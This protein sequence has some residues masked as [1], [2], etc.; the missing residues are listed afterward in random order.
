LAALGVA[1]RVLP[2]ASCRTVFLG[3]V[4]NVP[5]RVF[6]LACRIIRTAD[7]IGNY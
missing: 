5:P 6:S 4:L 1:S 3:V 7:K 2:S